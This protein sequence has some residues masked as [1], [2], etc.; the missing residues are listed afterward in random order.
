MHLITD[1]GFVRRLA[2]NL[3]AMP[4]IIAVCFTNRNLRNIFMDAYYGFKEYA[5]LVASE[6]AWWS[7]LGLLSSSCC[8]IQILLNAFSFGCAGFNNVLGPI[9]PTFI[10]MTIILQIGSWYVAYYSVLRQ[11]KMTALST[12][13]SFCLTLLPEALSWQT[14]R[15][16][17]GQQSQPKLNEDFKNTSL[18]ND[19]NKMG[20][21]IHLRFKLSTMG[22]SSCEA[23]V[24]K[25]L[26]GVD[27]ALQHTVTLADGNVEISLDE[28]YATK[29]HE[30]SSG[31]DSIRDFLWN[32]IAQ[33]LR[34][35]GFPPDDPDD[36]RK[37]R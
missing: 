2:A 8:A 28:A 15:G 24:S 1:D 36:S 27:G 17:F 25:V 19:D 16:R 31:T 13:L 26:D 32:D 20:R 30:R 29:N 34:S 11:W 22:C 3:L 10:A 18:K 4:I 35:S 33:R 12:I 7:V 21:I 6:M 9:R 14:R 37:E 23:T 5:M